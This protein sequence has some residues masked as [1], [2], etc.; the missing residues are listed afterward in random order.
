MP[1]HLLTDAAVR[2]AKPRGKKP[3]RLFDGEGLALRVAPS[4]VKSWQLR[5]RLHGKPQTLTIGKYDTYSLSDARERASKARKLAAD[6]VHLT[7]DKRVQRLRK[8][9]ETATLFEGFAARWVVHEARRLRWSA[10]YKREVE[11]S[12]AR[13]L[14]TLHPL[15]L[16]EVTAPAAVA[17][18]RDVER[19]TPMM[20][21][22]VRRRLRGILDFAVEEGLIPGNPLPARRRGPK[23]ERRHFPAVTDRNGVG[24]ILRKAWASDPA[25]GITRAHLLTT[26]TAQRIAEVVGAEW[27]EFDLDAG[28]WSIP[29]ARMKVRDEARGPHQVPI[30]RQLLAELKQWRAADG[31]GASFVCPTPR[32]PKKSITPE[33]VEKHYRDTLELAG[34]HSP[35]SWRSAFKTICADAGK[36][37]ETVEAQ[38]DHVVGNKVAAAYDR[39]KRLA[40]RHKLMQ[41]YESELIAAR[42]GAEVVPLA[43]R[44][45]GNAA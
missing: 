37:S 14:K 7:V 1:T 31:D 16:V 11:Q 26:F 15:P 39:A 9:A 32:D 43:S 38:L 17:V 24:A 6:G 35:H 28:L 12:I 22:K 2:K 34:K 23:L 8:R 19:A 42:D 44:P 25:K 10:D 18:L 29:R 36:D 45:K 33:G 27:S 20:A 21:E 4:G 40:L 5:Y 13:H 30:P 3:Y 41:W